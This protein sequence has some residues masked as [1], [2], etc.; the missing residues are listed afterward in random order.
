[1]LRTAID[2]ENDEHAHI[3]PCAAY[4][5]IYCMYIKGGFL[6]NN[7]NTVLPQNNGSP[8]PRRPDLDDLIFQEEGWLAS[9]R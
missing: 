8:A 2:A 5:D 1:M 9:D 3:T 4:I 7:D 6:M